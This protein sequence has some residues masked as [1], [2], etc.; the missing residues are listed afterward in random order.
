MNDYI[1]K[2]IKKYF[3]K[4]LLMLKFLNLNRYKW[5]LMAIIAI[6]LVIFEPWLVQF[7][8]NTLFLITSFVVF[9]IIYAIVKLIKDLSDGTNIQYKIFRFMSK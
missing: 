2:L 9:L 6:I 1:I 8:L 7:I 3:N 5:M 4:D